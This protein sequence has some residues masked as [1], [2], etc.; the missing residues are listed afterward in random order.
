MQRALRLVAV[1]A[2]VLVAACAHDSTPT[3][4][5][6]A[7]LANLSVDPSVGATSGQASL[8]GLTMSPDPTYQGS[9]AA[10]EQCSYSPTSKRVECAPVTRDG[11]TITR[12]MAFYDAA[13]AAQTHRDSLTRSTNT[14]V[15]VKGSTTTDR[16]AMA[17]D[18]VSSMTLSGLGKNATT[19]T[20]NGEE[21]GTTSGTVTT[22]NGSSATITESFQ[23]RTENV[24]VPAPFTATSWPVSGTT[25]RTS[26]STVSRGATTRTTTASEHATYNGTSKVSVVVTRGGTTHTCT[27]DLSAHTMSCP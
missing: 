25:T 12:S 3:V 18:R 10:T 13:G 6:D 14:Q 19:H 8:P 24:V 4:G 23:T 11:L 17:V 21:K 2:T 9:I 5:L 1:G 15:A 22:D 27:R 7:D 20:L 26:T 16:G